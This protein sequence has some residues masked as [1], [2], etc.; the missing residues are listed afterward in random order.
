[1]FDLYDVLQKDTNSLEIEFNKQIGSKTAQ[2]SRQ[3]SERLNLESILQF[4]GTFRDLFNTL[5]F[6]STDGKIMLNQRGDGIKVRHIPVILQNMAE[7]ELRE[8]RKREPIANTIWGFEEPENNLEFDSA[9]K[10][11]DQFIE[12]LDRIYFQDENFAKYDEGVQ[13]FISTHSPIFYT[14]GNTTSERVSTFFVNKSKDE[15]STIRLIDYNNSIQLEK[16]MKLLPLIELSKYWKDINNEIETLKIEKEELEKVKSQ[17][18]DSKKCIVLTEDKKQGLVEILLLANGFKPDEYEIQSY[19][20]CSKINSAE[21]LH[22]Y[23][24]DKFIDTC[25]P[26]LIHRDKDYMNPRDIEEE[27]RK[28]NKKGLEIFITKGTDIES[29]FTN[30]RHIKHCHPELSEEDIDN[31]RKLAIKDNKEYAIEA[32]K[33]NE[34]GEKHANKNSFLMDKIPE[35]YNT[36]EETL[37]HGKK[38]LKN[39]KAQI[40]AKTGSNSKLECQSEYLTDD[41][42]KEFSKQIW[43]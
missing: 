34:Y 12:Y 16:E 9:K 5:E 3:I 32:M 20:G 31:I 43:K 24:K 28:Y 21:V 33:K 39:I 38:V 42:L 26:I 1:M 8:E 10:L 18:T 19:N 23:L 35:Y 7:A 37:F 40:Q 11:A 2:I 6:G 29:Y 30:I 4:K 13:I 22:S 15:S 27:K 41:F 14:L 25:P 17:F 36:H